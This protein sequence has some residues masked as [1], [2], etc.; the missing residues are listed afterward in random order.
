MLTN[1]QTNCSHAVQ[2][3]SDVESNVR[4]PC[5]KHNTPSKSPAGFP[6]SGSSRYKKSGLSQSYDDLLSAAS[7]E[8][9]A[10]S[11]YGF[12]RPV[13]KRSSSTISR[14]SGLVG[15]SGYSTGS[16]CSNK[17]VKFNLPASQSTALDT[18]TGNPDFKNTL[19]F[20]PASSINPIPTNPLN[21][22]SVGGNGKNPIYYFTA[23]GNNPRGD[24][25]AGNFYVCQNLCASCGIC[26]Y[27]S[28]TQQTAPLPQA[29]YQH[30]VQYAL[31]QA[32]NFFNYQIQQ[33]PTTMSSIE[34]D[35]PG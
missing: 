19:D 7:N 21:V 2:C 1:S 5:I 16:L 25:P 30:N 12:V 32:Q 17:S 24:F 23:Q 6:K 11:T 8:S 35:S 33:T 28:T 26:P 20:N 4:R 31:I 34:Q 9:S 10:N 13:L 22:M 3:S 14:K 18:A 27:T 15:K 29:F